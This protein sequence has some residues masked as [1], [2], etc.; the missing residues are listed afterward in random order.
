MTC[1]RKVQYIKPYFKPAYPEFWHLHYK[2]RC[3]SNGALPYQCFNINLWGLSILRRLLPSFPYLLQKWRT[4]RSWIFYSIATKP[5]KAPTAHAPGV[6]ENQEWQCLVP[7]N[8]TKMIDYLN[9][10]FLWRCH[11]IAHFSTKH[12]GLLQL[13]MS[14]IIDSNETT[15]LEWVGNWEMTCL[16]MARMC[17]KCSTNRK[18]GSWI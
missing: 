1:W 14:R 10:R 12:L 13:Y 5:W 3:L 16:H 17:G 8:R 9:E 18:T 7:N 6:L 15:S 2:T 11:Q 4:T